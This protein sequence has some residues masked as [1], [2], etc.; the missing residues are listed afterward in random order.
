M[1][2]KKS[3][4]EQYV[5]DK[6]KEKRIANG[7][8]QS[9]LAFLMGVSDGFIGKIE[10]HKY[11]AKYNLNHINKLSLIF[12]CSPQEFLPLSACEDD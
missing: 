1:N 4:I 3:A 6:V 5:I 8:S 12:G 2:A 7:I 9:E 11:P 10:S